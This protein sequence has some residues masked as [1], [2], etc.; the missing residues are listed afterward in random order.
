[1]RS[2]RWP[3][4]QITGEFSG[5]CT[6]RQVAVRAAQHLMALDRVTHECGLADVTTRVRG[7]RVVTSCCDTGGQALRSKLACL[8]TRTL[9]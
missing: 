7:P 4:A 5:D 3:L 8:P 6:M 2:A 1:M 9:N